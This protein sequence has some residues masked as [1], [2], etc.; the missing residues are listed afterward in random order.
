MFISISISTYVGVC[1]H[2]YI[3]VGIY[4]CMYIL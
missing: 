3:Y 4:A 1:M 2:V